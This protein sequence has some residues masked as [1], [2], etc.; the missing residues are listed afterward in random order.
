MLYEVITGIGVF[1]YI[2]SHLQKMHENLINYEKDKI[3]AELTALKAQINPHLLFNTLNNIYSLSLD[4]SDKTPEMI[5]KLSD[6]MSYVLYD[7]KNNEVLRI[8]SYNV[9]Y[10]K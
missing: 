4:K 8:T 2:F 5:L 1:F 7:C 9:C 6:L 10:T 3:D